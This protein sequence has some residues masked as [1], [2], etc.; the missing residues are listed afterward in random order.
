MKEIDVL[1]NQEDISFAFD[2]AIAETIAP[3]LEALGL[4]NV[5]HKTRTCGAHNVLNYRKR[6]NKIM[7][8]VIETKDISS[9]FVTLFFHRNHLFYSLV[10]GNT[11]RR[12]I[13]R[14]QQKL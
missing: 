1:K 11:G 10:H 12:I 2:N 13:H 6:S 4:E 14:E 5:E 3:D 7:K 9:K 8:D